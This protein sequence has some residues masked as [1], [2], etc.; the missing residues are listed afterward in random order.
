MASLQ[1]EL[2]C[3]HA[4]LWK[5]ARSWLCRLQRAGP[6]WLFQLASFSQAMAA[7]ALGWAAPLQALQTALAADAELSEAVS[8]QS[9]VESI[10]PEHAASIANWQ[11]CRRHPGV[12]D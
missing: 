9:V 4:C 8:I 10:C 6:G 5:A 12:H 3:R 11:P 1:G 2:S 7:V